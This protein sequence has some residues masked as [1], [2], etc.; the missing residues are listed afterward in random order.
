MSGSPELIADLAI[1][2]ATAAVTGLA[3]RRL[4]QPS[5]LG[6][7]LAG[8]IVGPYIP[9]PLFADQ[10]RIEALAEVGVVLVM[11]AVGLELRIARLVRILPV[12]GLT[13]AVQMGALAWA[14]FVVGS[15]LGWSSPA[16]VCLGAALAISSTMVVSGV[17]QTQPV[18][19]DVRS[20]VFGVLVVQDVAAIVLIA[21]VTTLAEGQEVDATRLMWL[22]A[23]LG[24]VVLA[25]LAV[26]MVVMPRVVRAAAAEK[27]SEALAV[28]A[29][30]AAF[31]FAAVAGLFEYSVAL[32]AFI[33]GVVV[34]E[35]GR[36]HV[37]EHAIEPLRAVFAA[38][39]FVSIGM[40][41][42]PV[43]A[44]SSLP[45]ALGLTALVVTA[46]LLSVTLASVL[47]GS[48]LRKAVLSGLV[49]G[50]I[51]ELSFI[52]ASIATAGGVTPPETLPTLVT[53]A[54]LTAFTT[55]L[56][57]RRGDALVA[58][59]DQ[60]LPR[61]VHHL[62]DGYA[63]FIRQARD[64]GDG[65]AFTRPTIALS[66]DWAAVMLLLLLRQPV[67][68]A[69][70]DHGWA[71]NVGLVVLAVPF[72]VGLFRSARAWLGALKKASSR[73]P[74]PVARSVEALGALGMLVGIAMPTL[75]V[76]RPMLSGS[77]LEVVLG[78]LLVAA[79]VAT[80]RRV[81]TFETAYTSGVA[82]VAS[83]LAS[84]AAVPDD[85]T[86][87]PPVPQM[88]AFD[89]VEIAVEPGASAEGRSLTELDLRSRT[90]A[91]V[92]AICRGEETC[93]LPTGHEILR[94]HDRL[95]VSGAP[96]AVARARQVLAGPQ[97]VPA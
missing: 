93:V 66:L 81:A 5:I 39:F 58:S 3:A 68:R 43:V 16:S 72:V 8:L 46:Q 49:L 20:H 71:V 92:L 73:A 86:P 17:L 97:S 12:S 10:H 23:Q 91:T 30:G 22:V 19:E 79:A 47:S 69:L 74:G 77:W 82:R 67:L 27:D 75:A 59:I 41:V 15:L 4:G 96:D 25:M 63:S 53:V 7:L 84:Q 64:R 70:P 85:A 18:D 13:A 2:T 78:A 90:G 88:P 57:L 51:G 9:I 50:Q 48:D 6:Y 87:A 42:D 89:H 62:L 94:A 65:S 40:T 45:L 14:G 28:I 34:A 54:T 33:A 37:V 38:L 60:H 35:S 36:G 11:F 44:W 55:P 95:A 29:A 26:G 52:L 24:G 31:A 21:V 32:G 1:V 83:G 76:V 80:F 56:F 61:W